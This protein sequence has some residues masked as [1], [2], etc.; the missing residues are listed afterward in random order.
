MTWDFHP[1]FLGTVLSYC[2][3]PALHHPCG[4]GFVNWVLSTYFSFLQ[5]NR[6][7]LSGFHSSSEALGS[8]RIWVHPHLKALIGLRVTVNNWFRD[9]NLI[10]WSH[11]VAPATVIRLGWARGPGW[12][13]AQSS[14]SPWIWRVS[15]SLCT[16]YHLLPWSS[17]SMCGRRLSP[18]SP[19]SSDR[20]LIISYLQPIPSLDSLL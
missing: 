15:K 7:W 18:E 16:G 17:E 10:Q 4:M 9:L 5:P 13:E 8:H 19:R 2:V 1:G 12:K 3:S 14:F 20:S 6:A 11:D